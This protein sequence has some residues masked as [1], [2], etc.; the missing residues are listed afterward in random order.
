MWYCYC[1]YGLFKVSI[2]RGTS[3][4][5]ITEVVRCLRLAS[6]SSNAEKVVG[7]GIDEINVTTCSFFCWSWVMST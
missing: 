5:L 6:K 2:F 3:Q 4:V 7:E 1:E